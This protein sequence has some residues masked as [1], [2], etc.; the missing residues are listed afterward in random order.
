MLLHVTLPYGET[1]VILHKEMCYKHALVPVEDVQALIVR[2]LPAEQGGFAE[3]SRLGGAGASARRPCLFIRN[4]VLA[5]KSARTEWNPELL[6][7]AII[8]SGNK[9]LGRRRIFLK[10]APDDPMASFRGWPHRECLEI[11][12]KSAARERGI[13]A[14]TLGPEPQCQATS[15]ERGRSCSVGLAILGLAPVE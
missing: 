10:P 2:Q 7:L 3:T 5:R 12:A 6:S 15:L 4:E 14:P 8:P 1:G 11:S 9:V 13:A